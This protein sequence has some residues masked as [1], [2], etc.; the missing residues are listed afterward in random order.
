MGVTVV[1]NGDDSARDTKLVVLFPE[2]VEFQSALLVAGVNKSDGSEGIIGQPG[3]G[4]AHGYALFCLGQIEHGKHP[5][6]KVVVRVTTKKVQ[7]NSTSMTFGA[8]A[9]SLTPDHVP[10]N[11]FKLS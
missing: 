3:P 6:S 10:L 9:W 11:N 8:F 5:K 1:N 2:G 4:G 7:P